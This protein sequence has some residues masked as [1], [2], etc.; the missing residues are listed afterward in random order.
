M[1]SDLCNFV[2]QLNYVLNAS[3]LC[4]CEVAR[5]VF[6]VCMCVLEGYVDVCVRNLCLGPC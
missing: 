5:T 1:Q 2:N 3:L 6:T 4:V